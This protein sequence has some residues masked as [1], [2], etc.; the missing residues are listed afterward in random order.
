MAETSARDAGFS[1]LMCRRMPEPSSWKTSAVSP[2]ER[3]CEGLVVVQGD[4]LEI[5]LEAPG[6]GNPVYGPLQDG[7]VRQP[8]EVHL[9]QAQLRYGLHGELGHGDLALPAA[10]HGALEGDVLREGF[11]GDDHAGS[12]R[13]DVADHPF[14]LLGRVHE[15]P[16]RAVGP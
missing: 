12:V 10:A 13:A 6:L 8:Q 15:A 2:E 11:A 14:D 16:E 4:G 5:E 7:E 9:E 1:S 3:A